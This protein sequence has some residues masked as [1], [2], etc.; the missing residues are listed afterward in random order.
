[1]GTLQV[2]N[3]IIL[4][5]LSLYS[6]TL[7]GYKNAT[8]RLQ[9]ILMPPLR[10]VCFL[11]IFWLI[12][13]LARLHAG[14]WAAIDPAELQMKDLPEQPG[15][16]AL[17]LYHEEI[18]D[19]LKHSHFIYARIKVLTE[20]GRKYGDVQV[21]YFIFQT[22]ELGITDVQG[23]T[24][25]SDGSV[26]EFKG[27]PYDKTIV[28]RKGIKEQV[29]A[30]S[31]PDVQ[32]GSVLE[33][34]YTL[35]YHSHTL[36]PPEWLIQNELFQR[37]V[38]FRFIAYMDMVQTS[39]DNVRAGVAYSWKLPKGTP[40]KFS[41]GHVYDLDMTNVPAF[42]EEEHMP[43]TEPFRYSVRFY[44]G[45][46]SNANQY[47]SE[48]GNYWRQAVEKFMGNKKGVADAVAKVTTPNDS[49]EE[50]AKKIYAF[51][52]GLNNFSYQPQLSDKEM[53]ALDYKDRG[54]DDILRQGAG[55]RQEI[56]LLFIAMARAAGIQ[57]YPMWVTNRSRGIFDKNYMATDQLDSYVAVISLEGKEKFLDPGTKYCPYDLLYWP[58]SDTAGIRESAGGISLGQT[59]PPAYTGAITKRVGRFTL[60]DDGKLEGIVAV[61][62]MG[63][64]ALLRRIEGSRTDDVGRTKMLEDEIKGWLP[65][66]AEI[67]VTKQPD[68]S[69]LGTPLVVDYKVSTPT[70]ISGGKRV[71][72]PTDIF[73]FDRPAMFT[74]AERQYPV[75]LDYP[76]REIDDI[77][78]KLPDN[79]QVESLPESESDRTEYALYKMERKQD[80]NELIIVRD[81]AINSFVFQPAEYKSLKAFY[82]K[83]KES[84]QQQA[85][86][87]PIAHVAQN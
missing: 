29:K 20:A 73:Q 15:A 59:P 68:W 74:L 37:R 24:I 27:K 46:G 42:V 28:K 56:T 48:E 2:T 17:V 64:E 40:V 47:W 23:R 8:L 3:F 71:L 30:F 81:F 63:Q 12:A 44:Y 75:Y 31:L 77:H 22:A 86:L 4:S 16:P 54:A 41:Q 69:A 6:A 84:D 80:K 38:H 13:G 66:N 7:L 5:L 82:E 65:S 19:D 32:V 36:L 18:D 26:V 78:I 61:A 11:A 85:L 39:R 49:P 79:L 1:M 70:L 45:A 53:K 21:P 35:D 67:S 72:L 14:D 87:K 33:Y 58:H 50:K 55:T 83:I 25:H 34:R 10:R 76:S 57:A 62:Y 9:E 60:T 51:V 43:P 52:S